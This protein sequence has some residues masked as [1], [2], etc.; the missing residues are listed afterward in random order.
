MIVCTEN[1]KESTKSLFELINEF[2]KLAGYKSN[3]QNM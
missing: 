2:S 3:T 1:S